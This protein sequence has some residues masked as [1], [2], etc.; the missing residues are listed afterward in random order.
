M[1]LAITS[2]SAGF[3]AKNNT[4]PI[5]EDVGG[6]YV[7][8]HQLKKFDEVDAIYCIGWYC[9][10]MQAL[11]QHL[12]LL[13]RG[14]PVIVHWA[15]S[16]II[17]TKQ[18][19]EEMDLTEMFDLL[20]SDHVTMTAGREIVRKEALELGCKKVR[21]CPIASRLDPKVVPFQIKA[22]GV[23]DPL[24]TVYMPPNRLEFFNF[25][26]ILEVAKKLD[27]I[28]FILY[29]FSSTPTQKRILPNMSD[30]GKLTDST[31]VQLIEAANMHLR[32]VEH[33]GLS[34]S[35]IEHCLAGRHVI[36][37]QDYPELTRIPNDVDQIVGVI[38]E[39]RD[40]KEPRI[41]VSNYYRKHFGKNTQRK[42]ILGIL[43]KKG[44]Y[45]ES[46]DAVQ[47]TAV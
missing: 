23:I 9:T 7:N 8:W 39:I 12:D 2:F 44:V 14:V 5:F 6:Y 33:D 11:Q 42:I 32:M 19:G 36:C 45:D 22:G 15:G 34:L 27:D 47:K 18:Y 13:R 21:L 40:L 20:N 46:G 38:E 10:T 29:S 28:A 35:V 16:D 30:W 25:N 4:A 37:N 3:H 24:V 17:T 41:E 43:K 31:Y 1:K 26:T